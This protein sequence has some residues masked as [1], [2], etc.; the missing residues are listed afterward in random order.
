MSFFLST[1][2]TVDI[3]RFLHIAWRRRAK[4]LDSLFNLVRLHKRKKSSYF[5]RRKSP[6][7]T[8]YSHCWGFQLQN[9][10]LEHRWLCHF[11]TCLSYPC[12]K[13][14]RTSLSSHQRCIVLSCWTHTVSGQTKQIY[15]LLSERQLGFL[16]QWTLFIVGNYH[17]SISACFVLAL[18]CLYSSNLRQSESERASNLCCSHSMC[19][20]QVR[21]SFWLRQLHHILHLSLRGGQKLKLNTLQHYLYLWHFTQRVRHCNRQ[22]TFYTI[23]ST[24]RFRLKYCIFLKFD[25]YSEIRAVGK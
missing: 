21:C 19:T 6:T 13:L 10:R 7:T 25:N 2:A 5:V 20:V 17:E 11:L 15:C 12:T 14:H 9:M 23:L 22:D 18:C 8:R 24:Q 3:I 4:L 16:D 1:L